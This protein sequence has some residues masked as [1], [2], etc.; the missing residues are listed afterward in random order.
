MHS[1]V[2]I[3]H[4]LSQQDLFVSFKNQLKKDFES[5]GQSIHFID[6]LP[7]EFI[8][9]R[10]A[11]TAQIFNISKNSNN[12]LM[13]LLYRIDISEKQI[14]DYANK[15]NDLI[16]EN[17]IAELIIKRILQKVILKKHYAS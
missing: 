5:C 8:N 12:A 14:K 3:T 15:K 13:N 2:Q 16:F 1:L 4:F 9:L 11:I 17:V 10:E 6:A 7:S